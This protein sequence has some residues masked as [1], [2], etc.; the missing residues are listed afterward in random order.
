MDSLHRETSIA[1]ERLSN[2][3]AIPLPQPEKGTWSKEMEDGP[4]FSCGFPLRQPLKWV[5]LRNKH[6]NVG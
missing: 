3:K 5:A 4:R 6:P 1:Q 2:A